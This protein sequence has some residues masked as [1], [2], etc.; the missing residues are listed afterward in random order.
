MAIDKEM[1][2]KDCS[3]YSFTADVDSNPFEDEGISLSCICVPELSAHS[4]MWPGNVVWSF[5][6]FFVE[7]KN[8]KRILLF[9]A[10]Q[11]MKMDYMEEE[12][13]EDTSLDFR[14]AGYNEGEFGMEMM[15]EY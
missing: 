10:H 6:Y 12:D 5:N 8:V 14:I 4:I 15:M 11:G 9:T 1:N 13:H 2:L 7:K 3:V